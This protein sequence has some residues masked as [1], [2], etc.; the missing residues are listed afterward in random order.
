LAKYFDMLIKL[1][2]IMI[3]LAI[4]I[5]AYLFIVILVGLV[6]AFTPSVEP[7]KSVFLPSPSCSQ[8]FAVYE[9]V[10]MGGGS[11]FHAGLVIV[12]LVIVHHAFTL[13]LLFDII[14]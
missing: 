3:T 12:T 6:I 10:F 11:D 8:V 14:C 7:L 13:E 9:T 4:T 1:L 2:L 5:I